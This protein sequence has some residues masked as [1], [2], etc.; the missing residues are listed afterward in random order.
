MLHRS[1]HYGCET[2]VVQLLLLADPSAARRRQFQGYLPLHMSVM[3]DALPRTDVV[4][5]LL[6]ACVAHSPRPP[7]HTSPA[8]WASSR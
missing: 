6:Q 1:L 2:R 8:I 3:R 4:R 5:M 7:C